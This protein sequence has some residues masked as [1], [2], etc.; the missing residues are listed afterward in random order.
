MLRCTVEE[1]DRAAP[2]VDSLNSLA[3]GYGGNRINR[4]RPHHDR[5]RGLRTPAPS[6][7]GHHALNVGMERSGMPVHRSP[8]LVGEIGL[9][10]HGPA[11]KTVCVIA[12]FACLS[13]DVA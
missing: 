4:C 13:R 6:P 5:V 1:M 10:A 7:A 8:A 12:H 11:A 3:A 9:L 2:I